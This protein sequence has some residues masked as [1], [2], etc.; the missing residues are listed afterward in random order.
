MRLRMPFEEGRA[1]TRTAAPA[2][3][4]AV[5]TTGRLAS[6]KLA[7][8]SGRKIVVT[9][10]NGNAESG[11]ARSVTR[12]GA[13]AA[14]ATAPISKRV[15]LAQKKVAMEARRGVSVRVGGP[16]RVVISRG[17]KAGLRPA[18]ARRVQL[19]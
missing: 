17:E 14:A 13:A 6:D 16:P 3:A 1:L 11:G 8:T 19:D 9:G 5:A 18:L 4:A 2:P 15:E 10:V 7:T 12:P